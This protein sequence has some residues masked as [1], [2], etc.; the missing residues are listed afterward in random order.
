MSAQ[1]RATILGAIDLAQGKRCC[2]AHNFSEI[3][4]EGVLP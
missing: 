3:N 1:R 2:A 4:E